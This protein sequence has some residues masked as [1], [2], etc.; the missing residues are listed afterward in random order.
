M[1]IWLE[2]PISFS[3]EMVS[4]L[5][6][7][8]DAYKNLAERVCSSDTEVTVHFPERGLSDPNMMFWDYTYMLHFNPILEGFVQAEKEGYDAV[9]VLCFCDPCLDQAREVLDIPMVGPCESSLHLAT[10]M[11]R[12]FGV[13]GVGGRKLAAAFRDNIARYGFERSCVGITSCTDSGSDLVSMLLM[14]GGSS[15]DPTPFI[16]SYLKDARVLI[17]KGAEVLISGCAAYGPFMTAQ[18]ITEIDGVPIIDCVVAELKMA[19]TLVALKEAGLPWISREGKYGQ[20]P[21][22]LITEARNDF[23]GKF[24]RSLP[25]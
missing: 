17:D 23:T 18:G 8:S 7:V 14:M 15:S 16:E 22:E 12:R 10:V 1:K 20:P 24:V 25:F 9:A 11:G 5:Q 21:I 13:V 19:E 6:P 2:C 3:E 4:D